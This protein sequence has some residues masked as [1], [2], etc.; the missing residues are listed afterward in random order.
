MRAART[1]ADIDTEG[2]AINVRLPLALRHQF[3]IVC[4]MRGQSMHARVVELMRADIEAYQHKAAVE[5]PQEDTND[6]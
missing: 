1:G 5:G 3:K 4:V 6:G 2:G